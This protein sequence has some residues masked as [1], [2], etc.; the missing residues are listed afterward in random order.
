MQG[1]QEKGSRKLVVN[2]RKCW[3]EHH[4]QNK[5]VGYLKMKIKEEIGSQEEDAPLIDSK[6]LDMWGLDS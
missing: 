3:L 6:I 5:R 4:E 1:G 2:L